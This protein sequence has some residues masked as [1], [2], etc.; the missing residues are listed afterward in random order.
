MNY[1]FKIETPQKMVLKLCYIPKAGETLTIFDKVYI[2][3][4]V[5]PVKG[6]FYRMLVSEEI[7][8]PIIIREEIKMPIIKS[9]TMWQKFI[10]RIKK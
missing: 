4:K 8:T 9:E 6:N 10:R 1:R 2:I 7:R 5:I 3:E